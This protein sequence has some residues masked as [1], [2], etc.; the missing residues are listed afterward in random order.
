MGEG[1][2]KNPEKEKETQSCLHTLRHTI[3]S[4]VLLLEGSHC[5]RRPDV[6]ETH[7]QSEMYPP[8]RH[9][10]N[11]LT[12]LEKYD[13]QPTCSTNAAASHLALGD[14]DIYRP[15]PMPVLHLPARWLRAPIGYL[16]PPLHPLVIAHFPK[17]AVL[18]EQLEHKLLFSLPPEERT[19]SCT[20]TKRQQ[21]P[22]K[23]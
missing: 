20:S 22:D 4:P 21:A 9:N 23:C 10:S 11:C 1:S 5:G 15:R 12:L 7:V 13:G 17:R 18:I 14:V 19:W 8:P 6:L 2:H 16:L 3:L